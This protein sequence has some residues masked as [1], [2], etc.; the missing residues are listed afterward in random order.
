VTLGGLLA[1]CGAGCHCGGAPDDVLDQCKGSLD[2]P[3]S[4]ATDI[5][6]VIDNSGS[7]QEEQQKV[8]DQLHTF[9]ENMT[10][11]P[12]RNDF[13]L[14]V[15]TTAVTQNARACGAA[16]VE[17]LAFPE[18]AGTLQRGKDPGG[19]VANPS[20]ALVLAP[21][22]DSAA[23]LAAARR[24]IGQGT[25][26]SGQE[27]GLEAMRRAVSEP[28]ASG[29]NSGLLRPG[30]RLLV[31]IVSDEDD[32]SDSGGCTTPA[33]EVTGACGAA[34]KADTDCAGQGDYCLLLRPTDPSQGR[35]CSLNACDTV[36][37]RS[38]L[39]PVE[40]YVKFL[41]GLDDGTGTGRPRE[42]FLAVIGA[43]DAALSPARCQSSTTEAYGVARRYQ[44]AVAQMGENGLIDSICNDD[45]S[46]TLTRIAA[47][48]NAPQT[49]DLAR[50]P[51][52]A[53]LLFFDV[54]RA[55]TGET[56][57]CREGD[58]F[59]YQ[60]PAGGAPARATFEGRCRL[61]P[62]DSLKLRVVCAG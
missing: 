3:P 23:F 4:V 40:T 52:D 1:L 62:G 29:P 44:A 5:L 12:I 20:D 17:C 10:N 19:H 34:C 60:P 15:V 56:L 33:L 22:G 55:A 31:V 43:V 42:V 26:G 25:S 24:A 35:R 8:V 38:K 7:M 54:T 21:G 37:G 2:L 16:T 41:R 48:V 36:D 6:F 18:Q 57:T 27:M 53:R 49:V 45:Y 47:L 32:C 61:R 51:A 28:L 14:A 30:A 9:I 13:Q 58:G 50:P 59:S 46:Q 39:E 11:A